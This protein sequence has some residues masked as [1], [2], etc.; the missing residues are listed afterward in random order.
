A[1][2][3]LRRQEWFLVLGRSGLGGTDPDQRQER[4]RH[5]GDR[6]APF[7]DSSPSLRMSLSFEPPQK[8]DSYTQRDGLV[9]TSASSASAITLRHVRVT[10]REGALKD[11]W[12]HVHGPGLGE[13]RDRRR[14][15]CA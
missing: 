3:A 11:P 7:F 13:W 4:G 9:E 10:G 15:A 12:A 2:A 6:P 5:P 1:P 8:S 14:V